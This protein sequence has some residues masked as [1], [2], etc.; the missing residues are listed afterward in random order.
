MLFLQ[1]WKLQQHSQ[2]PRLWWS[3][4]GYLRG[5]LSKNLE[6]RESGYDIFPL[7]THLCSC[8]KQTSVCFLIF[9]NGNPP[10]MYLAKCQV[11]WW[12]FILVPYLV[13]SY[14]PG[15]Y[16]LLGKIRLTME[17][18]LLNAFMYCATTKEATKGTKFT[19]RNAN[20]Y[21]KIKWLRV[22][23]RQQNLKSD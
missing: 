20:V 22:F 6:K 17:W 14:L 8:K 4:M 2:H 9:I 12:H 1:V 10:F 11:S 13:S 23:C 19:L 21:L 16:S 5:I 7:V 18:K 15:I 3:K